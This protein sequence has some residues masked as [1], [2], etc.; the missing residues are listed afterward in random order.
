[1][2]A[3]LRRVL[4]CPPRAAGWDG[5]A[6]AARWRD[7]GYLRPPDPGAAR[8]QHEALCRGLQRAGAEVAALREAD[9]LSLDA[10]YAHDASIVTDRGA[11]VLRMGKAARA[12]EPKAHAAFY[13]AA[14]VPLLGTI[15]APGT[16]EGGDLLW[17]APD[18]LLAGRGY[19]TSGAG[20]DRLRTLLAPLGVAC[21]EAALPH[22][23]GPT[24][25]LH[26]MSLISL[27][28][29]R[30]ALVDLAW[31]SVSTVELLRARGFDLVEI[32]PSERATL[33]CNVLSLGD[34]RLLA[35]EE[36]RATNRRLSEAGFD[37]RT[38]PGSEIA[39]NGSG[40]PTCLTRPLLRAS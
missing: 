9:G 36:N 10:V 23:P 25:C 5:S 33:A 2:V 37:V 3:P 39:L 34:R 21:V 30:T 4:V 14:G 18:T 1:M 20:I 19:R 28:D 27:L 11:I 15:E 17:I 24:A 13:R 26:L 22:G 40:G 8:A 32:D 6:G 12:A 16:V 35:L 38:F 29:E 31:L 7:L